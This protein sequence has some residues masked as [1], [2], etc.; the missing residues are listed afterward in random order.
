MDVKDYEK[1]LDKVSSIEHVALAYICS[2][3]GVYIAGNTP[4]MADRGMY[5][6]I[7]SL[8]FGTAEQVGHEMD[9][10]LQYVSLNFSEKRLLVI[11]MGPLHLMGILIDRQCDPEEVLTKVRSHL[12]L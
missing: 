9:D 8:A 4:K 12:V 2:R 3:A 6:A 10:D 7:T 11:G 1:I 5:S